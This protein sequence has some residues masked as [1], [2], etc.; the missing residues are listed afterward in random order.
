MTPVCFFASRV[1]FVSQVMGIQK[2]SKVQIAHVPTQADVA[3]VND[4]EHKGDGG[5]LIRGSPDAHLFL[6]TKFE[7]SMTIYV[8]PLEG[9][10]L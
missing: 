5:E 1:V 6:H 2:D 3:L 10:I 8:I 9:P 4:P 7:H